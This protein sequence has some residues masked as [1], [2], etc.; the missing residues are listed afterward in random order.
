MQRRPAHRDDVKRGSLLIEYP[1]ACERSDGDDGEEREDGT[2]VRPEEECGGF[3][4][5]SDVVGAIL[6]GVDC[7]VDD[8]PTAR[9]ALTLVQKKRKKF[10]AP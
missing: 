10:D 2:D 9:K 1:R 4:A 5:G 7:I 8:C 6:A 3:D